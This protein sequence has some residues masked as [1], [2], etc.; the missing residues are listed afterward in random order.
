MLLAWFIKIGFIAVVDEDIGYTSLDVEVVVVVAG[1][2]EV[3]HPAVMDGRCRAADDDGGLAV[4][5]LEMCA[6]LEVT[7]GY[8]F[9][10]APYSYKYRSIIVT[11]SARSGCAWRY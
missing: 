7:G 3:P 5:G 11:I 9:R 1:D 4:G 8:R 6:G 2:G 10:N